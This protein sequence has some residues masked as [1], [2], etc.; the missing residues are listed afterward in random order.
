MQ[1]V[2][3]AYPGDCLN[4]T[5]EPA[6]K[7]AKA[8]SDAPNSLPV[9]TNECQRQSEDVLGDLRMHG[10]A[11]TSVNSSVSFADGT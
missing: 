9:Q 5:T 11:V 10:D 8:S 4:V 6:R 7:R 3:G 2:G 1:G